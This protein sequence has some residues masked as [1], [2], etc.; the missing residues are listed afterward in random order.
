MTGKRHMSAGW[1]ALQERA[2]VASS[3]GEFMARFRRPIA[4]AV[5]AVTAAGLGLVPTV[6]TAAASQAPGSCSAGAHTLSP[7]GARLYPETGNG[8]YRSVHTDV[9]MAYDAGSNTFLP[10]N[11]V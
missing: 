2:K 9:N 8:G 1:A 10:G 5:G 7:P 11:N 4:L 6:D 3:E